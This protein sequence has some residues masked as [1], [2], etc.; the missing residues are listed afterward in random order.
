MPGKKDEK[1][2]VGRFEIMKERNRFLSFRVKKKTKKPQEIFSFY[3]NTV[4]RY[5]HQK[6]LVIPFPWLVSYAMFWIF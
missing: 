2:A 3:V 1:K 6:N 5:I 4:R